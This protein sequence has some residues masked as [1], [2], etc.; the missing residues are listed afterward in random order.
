MKKV[1]E[2]SA[3]A[4]KSLFNRSFDRLVQTWQRR[5]PAKPRAI[6]LEFRRRSDTDTRRSA[7]IHIDTRSRRQRP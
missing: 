4:M 3:K 2:D 5:F 1:L 6:E 7:A